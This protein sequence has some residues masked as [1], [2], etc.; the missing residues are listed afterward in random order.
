[1]GQ[2]QVEL[3]PAKQPPT[4]NKANRPWTNYPHPDGSSGLSGRYIDSAEFDIP[5]PTM[6]EPR[7][8]GLLDGIAKT[9]QKVED[10]LSWL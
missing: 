2:A 7:K 3:A 10:V 1:M 9:I 8:S 4:D 6:T 5:M